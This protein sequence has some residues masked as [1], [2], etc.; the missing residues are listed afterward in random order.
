MSRWVT[1]NLFFRDFYLSSLSGDKED[2][3]FYYK[4]KKQSIYKS[5]NSTHIGLILIIGNIYK[6]YWIDSE[7]V[8][9]LILSNVE[10]HSMFVG[11]CPP[12][13]PHPPTYSNVMTK[14]IERHFFL[15]LEFFVYFP[16]FSSFLPFS[17]PCLVWLD[18]RVRI[19]RF[20]YIL[21]LLSIMLF[22]AILFPVPWRLS[23]CVC[24]MIWTSW[25]WWWS[26]RL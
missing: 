11:W 20:S 6:L 8:A 16:Y 21:F 17:V 10:C 12:P 13:S 15:L 14:K 9:S 3:L 26:H 4:D 25:L 23:T 2:R 7:T 22:F 18:E 5:M 24:N 19:D 1:S